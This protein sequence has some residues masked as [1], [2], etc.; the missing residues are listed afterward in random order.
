MMATHTSTLSAD[1]G[2]KVRNLIDTDRYREIFP[3]TIVSRD[4]SAS[5]NWATT[6]GGK[7]L[8]IGIGANVAGHG[9]HLLIADDLVSEQA[10]LANPEHV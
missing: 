9:A 2:R 10:V 7:Y 8:A 5:D 3:H 4:K 1:F 6:S